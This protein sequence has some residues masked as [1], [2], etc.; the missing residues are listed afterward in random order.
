MNILHRDSTNLHASFEDLENKSILGSRCPSPLI[1]RQEAV[2]FVESDVMSLENEDSKADLCIKVVRKEPK[3]TK[4]LSEELKMA[5]TN[6][7]TAA[8]S[9]IEEDHETTC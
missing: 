3:M 2:Q 8:T 1:Q 7:E 4:K 6:P 9:G 5:Q